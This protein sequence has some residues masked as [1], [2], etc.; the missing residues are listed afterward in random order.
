[1]KKDNREECEVWKDIIGYEG[2]YQV[3]DHGRV[4]SLDREVP[5][6]KSTKKIKGKIR[7]QVVHKLGY[8]MLNL[9]KNK[10]VK[11]HLVHRL[12][13][14][15]FVD[16]VNGHPEIN[17]INGIKDDNRATNLEWCTRE[18]NINHGTRT[19]KVR[20]KRS[21]R[22]KGVNVETGEVITLNSTR[23]AVNKGYSYGSV[24][25]ACRGVY[26]RGGGNLYRGHKWSY[27]EENK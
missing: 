21:K 15:H 9:S 24:A 27:E 3:S 19:E 26:N 5:L 4:R 7:K 2:Y 8:P 12:V 1:M 13:A 23:E 20:Q 25:A 11:G 16:N 22:V 18:H 14:L 6:G 10:E 17:H